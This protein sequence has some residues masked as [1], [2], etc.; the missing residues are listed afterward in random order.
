MPHDVRIGESPATPTAVVRGR[1]RQEEL[2]EVVP[3]TMG[4]VWDFLRAN[5]A[6]RPGRNVAV[7]L[8]GEI[9]LECGAEVAE[10]F[11]GNGKV[12]CSAIPA[13]PIAFTEHVG[14]YDRLNEAHEAV[15]RWCAE[16][17]HAL[18]GP[19]WEVYGH[20]VEDPAELRTEVCYLLRPAGPSEGIW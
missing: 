1:A 10:P 14:P 7:Y 18:A 11:Q 13:G 3:R 9:H 2:A 17:G 19:S 20:W 12:E 6:I 15:L 4:E 8:D 16:H 5:P